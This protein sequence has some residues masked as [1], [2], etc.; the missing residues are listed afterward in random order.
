M[1]TLYVSKSEIYREYEDGY[2]TFTLPVFKDEDGNNLSWYY[3]DSNNNKIEVQDSFV[4]ASVT[5]HIILPLMYTF[6][7]VLFYNK[8]KIVGFIRQ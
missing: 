8:N 1:I 5:L 3:Y 2:S 7:Y 4:V 6:D